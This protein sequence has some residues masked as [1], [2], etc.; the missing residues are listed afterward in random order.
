[1]LRLL[2]VCKNNVESQNQMARDS[3]DRFEPRDSSIVTRKSVCW[4]MI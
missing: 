1:M 3:E 4:L 2:N